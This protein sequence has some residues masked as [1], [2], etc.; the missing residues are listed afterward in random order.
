MTQ[1][2]KVQTAA[3]M[4][5]TGV[6]RSAQDAV[7]AARQMAEGITREGEKAGKG[8]EA[9]GAG[10]E[11]AERTVDAKTK[12]ISDRIRRLTQQSQRELAGLAASSAGGP[13]SAAAV[14][15]EATIRGADVA[16]LQPQIAALRDLQTQ[17][18]ALSTAMRQA[19]VGE[20]FIAGINS[21]ITAL[22]RQSVSAKMAEAD[23]LALRAAELGVAQ[24]A[25]PLI[26]KLRATAAAADAAAEANRRAA[27]SESFLTGLNAQASAIG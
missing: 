15:Y 23:M 10:A 18:S 14:E 1:E 4:D 20:E 12:S 26:A 5:V 11:K 19:M 16:K 27:A 25:D 9:M 17:A 8:L 22:Q 3:V 13:G 24:Q 6:E 21:R 7:R 2:K